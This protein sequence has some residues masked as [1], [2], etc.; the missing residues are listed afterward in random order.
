MCLFRYALK[1][2]WPKKV[3][4]II[5]DIIINMIIICTKYKYEMK[6]RKSRI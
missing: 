5:V 6:Y 4:I 2:I 1:H 3:L